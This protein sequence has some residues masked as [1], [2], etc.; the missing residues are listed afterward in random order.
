LALKQHKQSFGAEDISLAENQDMLEAFEF[1]VK[2][3]LQINN[4]L[5]YQQIAINTQNIQNMH[6]Q[7]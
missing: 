6:T 4:M 7:F 2:R 3:E 1:K 5:K